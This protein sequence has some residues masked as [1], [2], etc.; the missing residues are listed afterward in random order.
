VNR[1]RPPNHRLPASLPGTP[2]STSQAHAR[3]TSYHPD[4][5]IPQRDRDTGN[6]TRS[7]SQTSTQSR[8]RKS[9]TIPAIDPVTMKRRKGKPS[10]GRN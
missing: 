3:T 1:D 8:P 7:N 5:P 10:P 4:Q 9:Q 6:Q 2:T